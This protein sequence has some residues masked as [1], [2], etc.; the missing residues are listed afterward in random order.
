MG[1]IY[2]LTGKKSQ[3]DP[4]I[5]VDDVFE[6]AKKLDPETAIVITCHEDGY[7]S[8][9]QNGLTRAEVLM[10]LDLVKLELLTNQ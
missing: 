8:L 4:E 1:D 9:V 3:Q 6:E 2:D 7:L 10:Y 5:T